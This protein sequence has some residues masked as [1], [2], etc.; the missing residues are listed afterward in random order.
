MEQK[1]FTDI[2]SEM[3]DAYEKNPTQ[4]T[5]DSFLNDDEKKAL[6]EVENQLESFDKSQTDLENARKQ[7]FSREEW[8]EGRIEQRLESYNEDQRE[9]LQKAIDEG[10]TSLIINEEEEDKQ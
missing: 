2:L 6:Q 8:F 3:L 5:I 9:K 1:T 7:G 4:E 10:S